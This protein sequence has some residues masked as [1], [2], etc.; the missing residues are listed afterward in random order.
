LRQELIKKMDYTTEDK[1]LKKMKQNRRGKIFFA[2]DFAELGNYKA[3]SKALERLAKQGEIMRVSRGIYAIPQKSELLGTLT[4][5][6]DSVVAAIAKR[7]KAKI[8]PTGLFAENVLGLSTQVPVK[9][10]Y[11]TDGTPR[12]L[13]IG[14]IPL[15]FK[16]TTPK[17]LAAK[18]KISG[19]AIQALKSIRKDRITDDEVDK[20]V[21]LL[22]KENPQHLAHDI[23]LVPVWIKEIMRDAQTNNDL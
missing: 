20:I 15:I 8:I 13:M 22:K 12:K 7:D 6:F 17:N 19:L 9:A 1:I 3:C 10:V 18:G 11:L 16:K 23:K 14:K 2:N 4:P 21:S 5:S